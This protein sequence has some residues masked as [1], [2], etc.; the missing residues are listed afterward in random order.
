VRVDFTHK[1][2][3]YFRTVQAPFKGIDLMDAKA[4]NAAHAKAKTLGE[5]L[6]A[7]LRRFCKDNDIWTAG[8]V[9]DAHQWRFALAPNPRKRPIQP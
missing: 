7:E 9:I 1:C 8:R 2:V 5:P 3:D 4:F 6:S